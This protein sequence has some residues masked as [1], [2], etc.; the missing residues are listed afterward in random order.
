MTDT[1]ALLSEIKRLATDLK[2]KSM[3]SLGDD[4]PLVADVLLKSAAVIQALD[5]RVTALE[6]AAASNAVPAPGPGG[7]PFLSKPPPGAQA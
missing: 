1:V 7:A 3:F 6:K 5:A 4:I 2:T